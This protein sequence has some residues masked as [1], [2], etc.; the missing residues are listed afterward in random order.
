LSGGRIDL[1]DPDALARAAPWRRG[2]VLL[3]LSS[4][5]G[6]GKTSLARRLVEGDPSLALSI[7]ATTRP[8]RPG[9]EEGR[10]YFFL[11]GEEFEARERAGEMLETAEVHGRRYGTPRG[12]VEA[13]AAEGRSVVFDI[14]WQGA[15]QLRAALGARVA[16]IF[17]LPPSF[18]DL[19]ERLRRRAREGEEAI[20]RRLAGAIA[21]MAHWGEYDHVLVNR[22]LEET[23][24]FARAIL[25]S[26]RLRAS[27][28]EGAGAGGG[29]GGGPS[30]GIGAFVAGIAPPG[31]EGAAGGDS[32]K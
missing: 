18:A 20:R 32:A 21:E 3:V 19:E 22:S 30:G 13:A 5:S 28:A 31:S 14:D 12:P 26:E 9:E 16:S 2:G 25:A 24:E 1:S 8:R 23:A 11:T 7:S 29:P 4:P 15:R 17:L 10:D 6:G 27:R